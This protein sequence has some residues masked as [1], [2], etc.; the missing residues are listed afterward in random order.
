MT[1]CTVRQHVPS[2]YG[3]LPHKPLCLATL[4]PCCY[5][6]RSHLSCTLLACTLRAKR[7]YT[8]S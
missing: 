6:L 7:L 8:K 1:T 5:G 4:P 2:A 3:C